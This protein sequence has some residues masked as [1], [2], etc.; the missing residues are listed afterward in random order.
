MTDFELNKAIAEALS[1]EWQSGPFKETC[2]LSDMQG[3]P[4]NYCN[5][6]SLLM[7]LVVKHC[8]NIMRNPDQIEPDGEDLEWGKYEYFYEFF[9]VS[10]QHALA[11]CLLKVLK[12]KGK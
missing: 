2:T 5:N 7:P 4:L 6:W 9:E 11:L 12:A 1:V 10:P 8:K 3:N